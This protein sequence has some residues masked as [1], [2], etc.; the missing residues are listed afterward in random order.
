MHQPLE[1][2]TWIPIRQNAQSMST[3]QFCK[4]ALDLERSALEDVPAGNAMLS[5]VL[6]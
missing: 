1:T 6:I 5:S 3:I 2:L 4:G